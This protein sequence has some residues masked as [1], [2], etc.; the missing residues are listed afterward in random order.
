MSVGALLPLLLPELPPLLDPELPP[1]PLPLGAPLELPPGP[2]SPSTMG[3][4][5]VDDPLEQPAPLAT[6]ANSSPKTPNAFMNFTAVPPMRPLGENGAVS[7]AHE[8][9]QRVSLNIDRERARERGRQA[10]KP[11]REKET[12]RGGEKEFVGWKFRRSFSPSSSLLSWGL[13]GSRFVVAVV[14]GAATTQLSSTQGDNPST[15]SPSLRTSLQSVSAT[16]P[17]LC[18]HNCWEMAPS[19][20][21]ARGLARYAQYVVPVRKWEYDQRTSRRLHWIVSSGNTPCHRV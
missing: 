12:G 16:A 5:P 6:V 9:C 4:V 18:G 8:Q 19:I 20:V 3:P 15:T 11:P 14:E 7:A 17:A 21:S 2:P 10:A 1:L 13:G